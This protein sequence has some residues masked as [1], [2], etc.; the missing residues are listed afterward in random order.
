MLAKEVLAQSHFLVI[1]DVV[2]RHGGRV[3]RIKAGRELHYRAS[4]VEATTTES[5]TP[6]LRPDL[7]VEGELGGEPYKLFVEI[8]VR[9]KTGQ[10][11]IAKLKERGLA[12]IEIDLSQVPADETREFYED[13]ILRT[14]ERRWLHNRFAE[15]EQLRMRAEA[16]HEHGHIAE[17]VAVAISDPE[18]SRPN[19]WVERVT[20]A[21]LAEL[22]GLTIDGHRCFATNAKIWQSAILDRHVLSKERVFQLK[23][24][25][26]WLA[27][28]GL[29]KSA[30]L[31]LLTPDEGRLAHLKDCFP[32]FR[33]PHQ[34]VAGYAGEL[35]LRGKL[36]K[37]PGKHGW[38]VPLHVAR[39]AVNQGEEVV[40][41]RLRLGALLH[42]FQGIKKRAIQGSRMDWEVWRHA[43][44]PAHGGDTPEDLIKVSESRF[45]AL[46]ANLGELRAMLVL[47]VAHIDG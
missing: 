22:I 4:V 40:R 46:L 31:P 8:F 38:S 19:P 5:G 36:Q 3:R 41:W 43:P 16:E 47:R 6:N 2:A 30:F 34:V 45:Q 27:D 25:L 10:E 1:P 18:L 7:I 21:G 26:R 42:E 15:A 37:G 44:L 39:A 20:D 33:T 32:G 23:G 29:L 14:A 9:H 24:T 12:A 17:K 11:K 28:Q 35:E 13:A